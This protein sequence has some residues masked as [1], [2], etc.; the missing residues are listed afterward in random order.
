VTADTLLVLMFG[1][2]GGGCLGWL[3]AWRLARKL[4]AHDVVLAEWDMP[5]DAQAPK[6]VTKFGRGA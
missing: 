3:S 1:L 4:E 2:L 5:F 6:P